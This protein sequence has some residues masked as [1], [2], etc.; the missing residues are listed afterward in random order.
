[1]TRELKGSIYIALAGI[2]WSTTGIFAKNLLDNGLTSIEVSFIRLF[3]GAFFFLVYFIFGKTH[4]FKI[5]KKGLILTFFMGVITQGIFNLVFF[6]SVDLIGVINATVLLYLA[7]L[8]LTIFSV[9]IFKEKLT[10]LKS[11]GVLLSIV[12]SILALTGAVFDFQELS[13]IGVGYGVMAG[14]GYALV[15]VFG[16][17]GLQK[18]HAKTL[19]FYNSLF[20][21]AFIL[22][23]VNI[24]DLAMKINSPVVV[25]CSLG[26]G[27]FAVVL[28][29]L[30]YFEGISSGIDLSKVGVLSMIELIFAVTLSV[31][32]VNEKLTLIKVFGLSLILVAIYLINKKVNRAPSIH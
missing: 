9:T 2:S 22:P 15:S 28:A 1:M 19:I 16:K 5:D 10:V 20:G 3:L 4:L 14:L 8:F 24:G 31:V 29:Y 26:L 21:M 18:Y 32:F 23:L 13:V 6:S 12:G 25:S 30:F 11:A 27:I 17:F 7:P